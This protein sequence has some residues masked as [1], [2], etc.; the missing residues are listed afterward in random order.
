MRNVGPLQ[1]MHM[2]HDE[3]DSILARFAETTDLPTARDLLHS[4]GKVARHHFAREEQVLFPTANQILDPA[5]LVR[6]GAQWAERRTVQ[7]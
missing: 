7:L 5:M 3:I 4:L 6:Q 1:V 2:E